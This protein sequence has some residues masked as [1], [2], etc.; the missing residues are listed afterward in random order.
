MALAA[1]IIGYISLTAC[2]AVVIAVTSFAPQFKE[3]IWQASRQA[4]TGQVDKTSAVD[5]QSLSGKEIISKV[6][7]QLQGFST[8]SGMA[9]SEIHIDMSEA[10]AQNIPVPDGAKKTKDSKKDLK[11]TSQGSQDIA[12]EADFKLGR[13]D[14]YRI[15]MN[16]EVSVMGRAITNKTTAWSAGDGFFMLLPGGK[17]Y[18]KF[19]TKDA[20]V[21]ASAGLLGGVG[22]TGMFFDD[23][24]NM[25]NYLGKSVRSKDEDVDGESCY[26]VKSTAL[27]QAVTLW[28]KKDSYLI[29][30]QRFDFGG[31][32]SDGSD[33]DLEKGLRSSGRAATPE[34]KAKMKETMQGMKSMLSKMKG[35]LE[36]TYTNI[37]TNRTFAKEAFKVELPVDATLLSMPAPGGPKAGSTSTTTKSSRKGKMRK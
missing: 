34:Q 29:K 37:E 32:I 8:L 23:N 3:A 13:P 4:K 19:E 36:T 31:S 22:I 9:K 33:Q 17:K 1:L 11:Q 20:A 16:Q 2:I 25:A 15:D 14:L 30:K 12:V 6:S 10:E 26:V 27:G 21:A 5:T 28:I 7:Q 24:N 18:M 35:Y